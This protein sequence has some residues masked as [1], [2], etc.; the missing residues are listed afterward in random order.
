MQQKAAASPM[1]PDAEHITCAW[2]RHQHD[3]NNIISPPAST[4]HVK[5]QGL[6]N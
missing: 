5:L 1:I 6:T 3:I 2:K 4:P